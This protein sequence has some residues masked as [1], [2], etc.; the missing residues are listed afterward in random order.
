MYFA[1]GT[2][3]AIDYIRATTNKSQQ[4]SMG[5][6][7]SDMTTSEMTGVQDSRILAFHG[8]ETARIAAIG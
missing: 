2:E 4:M 5:T 6:L 8:Y 7:T 1:Y 3:G